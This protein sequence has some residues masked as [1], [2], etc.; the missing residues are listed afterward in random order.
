M[1]AE[2]IVSFDSLRLEDDFEAVVTDLADTLRRSYYQD[3]E[4]TL[5]KSEHKDQWLRMALDAVKNIWT[6]GSVR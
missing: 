6:G 4:A 1:K 2:E 3:P 5:D